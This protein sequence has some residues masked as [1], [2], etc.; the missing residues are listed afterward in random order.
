[1]L[2]A[3]KQY[4]YWFLRLSIMCSRK[5]SNTQKNCTTTEKELLAIV[6]VLRE[7]R[8]VLLG[9]KIN[10]YIQT[11][12][13]LPLHPSTPKEYILRWRLK[14]LCR[15]VCPWTVL[16]ARKVKRLGGCIFTLTQVWFI[17]DHEGEE[18]RNTDTI[19][20]S[21]RSYLLVLLISIQIL[22][23]QN[24]LSASSIY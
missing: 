18:S 3:N 20:S 13:I 2:R 12:R 19:S 4:I 8:S 9:A 15:R 11:T 1:M 10:I 22:R 17:W 24:Y 7:F 21:S 16:P 6:M 14:V 23:N 5:L